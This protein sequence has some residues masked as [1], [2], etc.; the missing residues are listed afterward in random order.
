MAAYQKT[1]TI[2]ASTKEVA[3]QKVAIIQNLAD[4]VSEKAIATIYKKITK[5]PEWLAK[6]ADH[7]MLNII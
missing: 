2:N 6:L 7:P 1:L 3:Q 5:N 4:K